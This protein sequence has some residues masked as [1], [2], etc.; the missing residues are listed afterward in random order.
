MFLVRGG[1]KRIRMCRIC[2]PD[3]MGTKY[4]YFVQY[5]PMP[6]SP[7]AGAARRAG[8][9]QQASRQAQRSNSG[10][11]SPGAVQGFVWK[12]TTAADGPVIGPGHFLIL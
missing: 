3:Q 9:W 8:G 11:G 1:P 7:E 10:S 5:L 6:L 2:C 12:D 4:K